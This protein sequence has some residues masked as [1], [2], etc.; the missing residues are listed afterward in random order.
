MRETKRFLKRLTTNVDRNSAP[1]MNAAM[2]KIHPDKDD[3]PVVAWAAR[4]HRF[5]AEDAH[6]RPKTDGKS[7]PY[8]SR[9]SGGIFCSSCLSCTEATPHS[10]ALQPTTCEKP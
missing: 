1:M 3:V 7:T 9:L 10:H 4:T 5:T 6:A 2:N 8:D